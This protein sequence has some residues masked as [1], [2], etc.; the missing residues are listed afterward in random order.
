[1]KKIALAVPLLMSFQLL[2]AQV[3]V[4]VDN[5]ILNTGGFGFQ[6]MGVMPAGASEIV[7]PGK[8]FAFLQRY[9]D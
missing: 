3:T 4:R 1:M 6:V 9:L 5:T 2:Q 7:G 8:R